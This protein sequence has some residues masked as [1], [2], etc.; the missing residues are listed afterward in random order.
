[1]R[2]AASV[3]LVPLPAPWSAV[4]AARLP[5]SSRV[6]ALTGP[7]RPSAQSA[8]SAQRHGELVTQ[9]RA[10]TG[11]A[12]SVRASYLLAGRKGPHPWAHADATGSRGRHRKCVRPGV[13]QASEAPKVSGAAGGVHAGNL[14]RVQEETRRATHGSPR[15][16]NGSRSG[17]PRSGRSCSG[18]LPGSGPR[19]CVRI[20][21]HAPGVGAPVTEDAVADSPDSFGLENSSSA[22]TACGAPAR[23]T[24]RPCRSS[25]A[26]RAHAARA[27]GRGCP[28]SVGRTGPR[29]TASRR[30]RRRRQ[31]VPPTPRRPGPHTPADWPAGRRRPTGRRAQATDWPPHATGPAGGVRSASA[32]RVQEVLR[33]FRARVIVR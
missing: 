20:S 21:A 23:R 26:G 15:R 8:Q 16:A 13:R 30:T 6:P 3:P 2:T 19:R 12:G 27:V 14:L 25:P 28:A 32:T 5:Y 18:R 24:R 4:I 9:S 10:C 33:E 11:T 29:W 7:T 22:A 17:T 1:M 31:P